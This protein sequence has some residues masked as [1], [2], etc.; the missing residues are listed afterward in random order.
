MGKFSRQNIRILEEDN[1]PSIL[2]GLVF[3]FDLLIYHLNQMGVE[4]EVVVSFANAHSALVGLRDEEEQRG[5]L[6]RIPV[7]Y[8]S[9]DS[10]GRP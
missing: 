8:E 2:D 5:F 10:P 3:Q 6:K 7:S 9:R 1:D 4:E